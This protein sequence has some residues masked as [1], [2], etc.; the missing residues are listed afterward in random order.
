MRIALISPKWNEMVNSYPPLGLGYLAAVMEQQQHTVAIFDLG[1]EPKTPLED[2]VA[3]IVAWQPDLIGVTAMTNNFA[4]AEDMIA[5]LRAQ[6]D[7]PIVLGGPHATI[8]P[9][10]LAAREQIDYVVM[11]EGEETT[12]E[13]VAAIAQEGR[14]PSLST[15]QGILGLAY[16]DGDHAVCNATRPPDSRSGCAADAGAAPLSIGSLPALCR[17]R[18]THGDVAL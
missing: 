8:F 6:L 10:E 2:D 3:R 9:A 15:L 14:R 1:L 17:Q 12:R 11:G 7:V 18:R 4:S 16:K 5:L 13:L